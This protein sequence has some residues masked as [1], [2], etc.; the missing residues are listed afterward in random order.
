VSTDFKVVVTDYDYPDL[1]IEASILSKVGAKVVGAQCKSDDEVLEAA[2]DAR[3][4]LVQYANVGAE[5][6]AKLDKCLV[7]ARYGIGVD[8]VDVNAATSE[9]IL[10]TNVP[11][12]CLDEVADHA[13]AMFLMMARRLREYDTA[14]REG[15][16]HWSASGGRVGR[17]GEMVAGI[18]AYGRIGRGIAQRLKPFG[19]T[20]V[21]YDPYVGREQVA[22][23]GCKLVSFEELVRTSDVVFIQAPLTGETRHMFD[24]QALSM[25]KGTALII[26][27]ARGPIIDDAALYQALSTGKIAGAALDDLEEEPA[28]LRDWRPD[29][30]LLK[31]D[32]LL[33]SPHAAYY[34]EE[35]I[36][37]ARSTAAS[38][39]ARVL[40]G[41]VP[42]HLV[43]RQVLKSPNLRVRMSNC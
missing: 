28:K 15:R 1:E 43:N 40:S 35:S 22:E 37:E 11:D 13:V 25:M 33:I 6:I 2:S 36:V 17:I 9:G 8:I 12:Y 30:P 19:P 38:E 41:A 24:D 39:V 7:I 16:W 34:S 5:T 21:V 27:T 4:L 32:N 23:D 14:V 10:V 18:V 26:N 3:A 20:I 31:L 42:N 29:N